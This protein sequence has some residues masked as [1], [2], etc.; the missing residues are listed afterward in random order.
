MLLVCAVGAGTAWWM[1]RSR[2]APAL[3]PA[4]PVTGQPKSGSQP[5]RGT[6]IGAGGALD[7]GAGKVTLPA[8]PAV[9]H[10]TDPNAKVAYLT[11]D[12]GPD[13]TVTPLV[14]QTLQR[15]G[16][17][18]T[19]FVIGLQVKRYPNLLREE[20]S[21][22][23]SIGNH[24][25]SHNPRF[26]Y[27]SP[28]N[29]WEDF[30]KDEDIIDQTIGIRPRIYRCPDGSY[31]EFTAPFRELM[32]NKGYVFFDWNVSAGDAS[33]KPA[34][35]AQIIRNVETQV[36]RYNY[37]GARVIILMHDGPGHINTARALPTI[38]E[39]LKREGFQFG[40]LDLT[41]KPIQFRVPRAVR[42]QHR[43]R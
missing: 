36:E 20:Y 18:A 27:A 16:V 38:I 15:E 12:D 17:K 14:L 41:V 23:D 22:G 6:G 1:A 35:T 30:Q 26:I 19:F 29:F 28:Q 39:F 33:L 8:Q 32:N 31:P 34:S 3:H 37:K 5:P 13:G 9:V 10:P 40:T 42:V 4:V 43:V 11:F 21:D 7:A 25:Y 24:T 2:P